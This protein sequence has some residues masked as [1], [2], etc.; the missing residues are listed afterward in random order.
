LSD[1][2][3]AGGPTSTGVAYK[4]WWKPG[5]EIDARRQ[6]VTYDDKERF[7]RTGKEEMAR[8]APY[9]TADSTVV[10][11]GCGIGR[12]AYYTAPLCRT[13]WAVDVS[14]EMLGFAEQRLA[15]LPNVRYELC[16]NTSA[17]G[18]PDTSADFVYAIIVLQHLEREDA[19]M[20]MRDALRM[21]R[22]GGKAFFTWPNLLDE[23]YAET[24]VTYSETGE[25]AN[26]SRARMYTTTELQCI[27]PRVGFSEV[28]VLD[29]PNIVT[30]CTR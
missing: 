9:I 25:V 14:L 1:P 7:E 15:G 13:L 22:P 10:D 20:L 16:D 3:P 11:L 18:V 26:P 23:S 24:F 2:A 21:L 8:L 6:I 19:F 12:I 17:K 30:I 4:D 29:A 5:N 27:L 28:T